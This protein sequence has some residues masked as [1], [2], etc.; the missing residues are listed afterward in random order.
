MNTRKHKKIN[1]YLNNRRSV[2]YSERMPFSPSSPPISKVI[3]I[4]KKNNIY[5]VDVILMDLSLGYDS[6]EVIS[7]STASFSSLEEVSSFI[8][9][10]H[11]ITLD[12]FGA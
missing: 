10:K 6:D 8:E 5:I 2:S 7:E 12:S 1:H 4:S 11:S 9:E 3:I